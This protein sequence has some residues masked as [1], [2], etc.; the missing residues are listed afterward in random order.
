LAADPLLSVI[1]SSIDTHRDRD[2]RTALEPL[3]ALA[4]STGCAVVGLAHFNKSDSSDALN[5]ITGSRAFSAVA[6]AVVAIARD[7]DSDDGSC[8]LSQAKNNLGRLDL[9]SLRY[10]ID[11]TDVPTA[12]GPACV[13]RVRFTG[14]S[15]RT[16]ADILSDS[17]PQ[18]ESRSDRDAAAGWLTDYLTQRGGE[19]P[20]TEIR[21]AAHSEAIAD[22]TLQRACSRAG[23]TSTRTGFP[24]R[25]VWRL[26]TTQSRQSRQW[27]QLPEGDTTG[28][29]CGATATTDETRAA[30]TLAPVAPHTP[31]SRQD[32]EPGATGATGATAPPIPLFPTTDDRETAL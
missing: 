3:V 5:L 32:S 7:T 10:V 26:D 8:V 15:E 31:V 1:H 16:V 12:D 24:S 25:T 23:V 14:E 19:A 21:K 11:S 27:R 22:R 17:T 6:R 29:D 9:P 2:L 28:R 13:G 4:D 30:L 18:G 20:W